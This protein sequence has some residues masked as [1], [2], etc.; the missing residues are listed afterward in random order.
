MKPG[1]YTDEIIR[2]NMEKGYW[3]SPIMSEICDRN[4]E[5]Y[6]DKEALVDSRVRLTFSQMK[7]WMD[8]LALGLLESG[9]KRDDV[10]LAQ[11]S[12]TAEQYVLRFACEKAGIVS[13]PVRRSLGSADTR[14]LLRSSNATGI[15]IPWKYHDRD[16]FQEIQDIRSLLPD[17]K[18]IYIVDD[19]VPQ[20]AISI[21]I[22]LD[23]DLE[24]DFPV[25]FLEER[26][27]KKTEVSWFGTTTGTTGVP[28]II[29]YLA[30]NRPVQ[31][32]GLVERL[33]LTSE[34]IIAI[35]GPAIVGPNI[36]AYF[37]APIAG[38]KVATLEN[39]HPEEALELVEREKVTVFGGSPALLLGMVRHP[40]FSNY[41]HSSMRLTIC[42]G[43]SVEYAVGL[44]IETKM[45]CTV[46][47]FFGATDCGTAFFTSPDDPQEIRIGTA[48]KPLA[49][50][51]VKIA[52]SEGNP[53]PEGEVG[54]ILMTG[55]AASDGYLG[56]DEANKAVWTD[57]G[58]FRTGDLGRV[59][60]LGNLT[61]VGRIKDIII[62]GGDNVSPRE[63]EHVI[64][65]HPKVSL[66][67]VVGMPDPV[68]G[69]RVCAFVEPRARQDFTFEEMLAFLKEEGLRSYMLPERLE[70]V[71]KMPISGE[72]KIYKR[73]LVE[74]ITDK[75]KAEGKI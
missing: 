33:K 61:H 52:D 53:V 68:M 42:G 50:G 60:K 66:V 75:L 73:E 9:M 40:S 36:L 15:A 74:K 43:A 67:A 14:D 51:W 8:R 71:D 62:R 21:R 13:L 30:A 64:E 3:N 12:N 10:L 35:M 19:E 29:R 55:P 31:A 46:C 39:F 58:W 7:L 26:R 65:R 47:Q 45:E 54:E 5:L 25:D 48:G 24:K 16:H 49:G 22:M 20:G 37:G 27:F 17:L 32:T 59:D 18:N 70:I 1:R 56:D 72:G 2:E 41:D 63:I 38:A 57:D 23:R 11:L 4:A 34:D 6:P 69:E 28:K 44:E